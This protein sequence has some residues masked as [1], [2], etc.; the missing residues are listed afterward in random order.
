[1][2]SKVASQ[3]LKLENVISLLLLL[4]LSVLLSM[5]LLQEPNEKARRQVSSLW[6]NLKRSQRKPPDLEGL[7]P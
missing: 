5:Q 1:M 6:L 3:V 7:K 4:S 2:S